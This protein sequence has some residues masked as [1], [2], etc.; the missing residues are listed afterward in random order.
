MAINVSSNSWVAHALG[1]KE[2][3]GNPKRTQRNTVI[4]TF[5]LGQQSHLEGQGPNISTN[6]KCPD[7]STVLQATEDKNQASG[8]IDHV[9]PCLAIVGR[10]D[11][12]VLQLFQ[13]PPHNHKVGKKLGIT[14]KESL[15]E[16]QGGTN[17]FLPVLHG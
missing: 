9:I 16:C 7:S 11:Y 5:R 12:K 8:D 17:T 3:K 10:E 2:I 14:E 1:S 15:M 4:A 6:K 13:D